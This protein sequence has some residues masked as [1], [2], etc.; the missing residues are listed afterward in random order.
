[1][2]NPDRDQFHIN[3]QAYGYITAAFGL[4]YA[5]GQMVSGRCESIH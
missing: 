4:S 5:L 2:Y 1:M 3:D